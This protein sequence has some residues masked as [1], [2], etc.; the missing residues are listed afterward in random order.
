MDDL[1][2]LAWS[3]VPHCTQ[4]LAKH[5]EGYATIQFVSH[6]RGAFFLAYD[7]QSYLWREGNWF[8]PA[9]PGPRLRFHALENGDWHHRHIGFKGPLLERWRAAG[10]W[11]ETPQRAPQNA[12]F[13]VQMDELIDWT[14]RGKRLERLRAIN[15][16]ERLLLE[17]AQARET[18]AHADEWLEIVLARLDDQT[19]D[20]A[21]L[22]RDLG[23]SDTA[24]RRKF[25]LKTGI[26]MQDY[27]LN[28]KIA[29]ARVLLSD[30][31]MPLKEV[32][33]QLGYSNEF[34]FSR[35]F[36]ERVGVAP[37]TFR[38]SRLKN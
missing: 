34:F 32:A 38:K 6:I 23:L 10:L 36:K 35:Q 7:E 30:S 13:A 8:F 37:G 1:I 28:Q 27:R 20:F 24:L 21:R 29:R 4:R 16:L 22:G 12:D 19:L 11:L 25:K 18:E 9:F 2:L 31:S 3:N 14:A 26:S 15:G 5:V 33:F 17:L